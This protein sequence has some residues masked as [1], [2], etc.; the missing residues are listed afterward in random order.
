MNKNIDLVIE[1]LK[2]LR[3]ILAT[4]IFTDWD[5]NE[6]EVEFEHLL[7]KVDFIGELMD[8]NWDE[9]VTQ[10]EDKKYIFNFSYLDEKVNW[11]NLCVVIGVDY[12]KKDLVDDN[13]TFHLTKSQCKKLNLL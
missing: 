8:S 11:D 4:N 12:Y 9:D 1:K 13:E 5:E 3:L 6:P 7:N 2:E 10:E